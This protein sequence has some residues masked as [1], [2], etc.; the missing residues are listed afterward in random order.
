MQHHRQRL[1][2]LHRAEAVTGE[3]Y[4]P[5]EG[6]VFR[7]VKP[8]QSSVKAM[9]AGKG[10]RYN[11]G[12]WLLKGGKLATYTSLLP[13]TALVEALAA[14]RYYGFPESSAAPLVFVTA[15]VKLKKVLDLR[16]GKLRQRLRLSEESIIGTDWRANNSTKIE[17]ITQA[18]GWAL[19]ETGAEGF[20]CQSAAYAGEANLIIF[21]ENLSGKSS[22]NVAI[23]VKWPRS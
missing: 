4:Q 13:E 19:H 21:P 3:F 22:V 15:R 17:A 11:S 16:D 14:S 7:F 9:F 20:L 18:W 6:P 1:A 12:R 5:F 10:P 23:E 2:L 8:K